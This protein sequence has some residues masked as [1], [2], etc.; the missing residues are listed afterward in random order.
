MLKHLAYRLGLA[1]GGNPIMFMFTGLLLL[2]FTL[3][4]LVNIQITNDPQDL[5]VPPTSTAN[6]QQNYFKEKFG[7][8]FR[9]NTLW[10][11][12]GPGEDVDADVFET[13]YLQMLYEL[14]K[15]IEEETTEVNG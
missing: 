10:L 2:T 14:Q 9:I 5:W 3:C 15:A 1:A 12:P 6:L 4:G 13:G 8:F 11:S 7:P